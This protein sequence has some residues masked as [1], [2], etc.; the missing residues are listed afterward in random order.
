MS[1]R[2]GV[3][4][5]RQINPENLPKSQNLQTTNGRGKGGVQEAHSVQGHA[6]RS[7]LGRDRENEWQTPGGA[8]AVRSQTI[9]FYDFSPRR[10]SSA[11]FR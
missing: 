5:Q 1:E 4:N 9:N 8:A 7:R 10:I 2:V 3:F 6:I 11:D